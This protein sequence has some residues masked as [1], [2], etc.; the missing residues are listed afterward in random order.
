[1][2]TSGEQNQGLR[3]DTA[4]DARPGARFVSLRE[5]SLIHRLSP[6]CSAD[7]RHSRRSRNIIKILEAINYQTILLKNTSCSAITIN[8]G[9]RIQN[10]PQTCTVTT[11]KGMSSEGIHILGIPNKVRQ[12]PG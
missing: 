6:R 3:N 5:L 2:P 7:L 12:G 10:T 9:K 1:M 4:E 8:C 11:R